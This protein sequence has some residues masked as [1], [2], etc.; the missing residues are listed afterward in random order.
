MPF[1]EGDLPEIRCR[2]GWFGGVFFLILYVSDWCRCKPSLKLTA[3]ALQ[4]GPAPKGKNWSYS[5]HPF[6]GAVAAS[7]REGNVQGNVAGSEFLMF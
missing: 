3:K 1:V 6:S 5:N 7:F 4:I 2:S